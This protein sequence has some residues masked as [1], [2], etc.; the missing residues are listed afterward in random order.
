MVAG[1]KQTNTVPKNKPLQRSATYYAG[2]L[3]VSQ[4]SKKKF[5]KFESSS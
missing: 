2:T 1:R 3:L 4:V 5:N